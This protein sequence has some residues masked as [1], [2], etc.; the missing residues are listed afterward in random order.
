MNLTLYAV[1]GIV[2]LDN[3]G[4]RIFA[5]YFSPPHSNNAT[6]TVTGTTTAHSSTAL[7]HNVTTQKTFEKA[8]FKKTQKQNAD[9]V[10]FDGRVVCYKSSA[11]LVM[12]VIG[13]GD[14]NELMIYAV[15]LALRESLEL[16][17]RVSIDKRVLQEQYDLLAI[18]VD[19]IC[20]DGVI[21]ETDPVTISTRVTRAPTGMEGGVP[22]DFSEKGLLNAYQMAKKELADRILR[23]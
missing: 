9:V 11:D 7:A 14:E 18:T 19:E 22:L 23:G 3:T 13:N 12:Y 17:L 21:L 8:L 20:D 5:R 1:Q 15:V 10:L 2:I 16:L 6:S 4:Q